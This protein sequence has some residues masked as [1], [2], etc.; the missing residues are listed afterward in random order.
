[1]TKQNHSVL[2]GYGNQTMCLDLVW[3]TLFFPELQHNA[4]PSQSG[5]HTLLS[6]F[7]SSL[8]IMRILV[9]LWSRLDSV[10]ITFENGQQLSSVKSSQHHQNSEFQ[11]CMFSTS[12]KWWVPTLHVFNI[13]K[14][15]S[16]NFVCFSTSLKWWV[17]TLCVFN[18]T[19]NGEFQLCM[20]STSP[21]WWVPTLHVFN[22]TKMVSSNFACFQYH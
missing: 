17:P 22:I 2:S 6:E 3:N 5:S 4:G 16:S 11:L 15:V 1:M 8:D 7:C 21:K 18:I 12:P 9:A 14:M 13:T 10:F 19:K 20:F